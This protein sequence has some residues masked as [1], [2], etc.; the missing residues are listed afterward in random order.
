MAAATEARNTRLRLMA[1][2]SGVLVPLD[3]VPDPVFAQRLVGDGVS[4]DPVSAVLLAPC[5]GRITQLH[6]AAHALTIATAAGVEVMMHIGLDTV[7]LKGRG[8]VAR[9][10]TGDDVRTG[11]TLIEFDADFV[12]TNARSLLTQ[13]IITSAD[14]V[15]GLRAHSGVVQAGRDVI[16]EADVRSAAG[17]AP[18]AASL[19]GGKVESDDIVVSNATGLHARPAAVLAARARAFKSEIRLRRDGQEANAKSVVAIMALEV[20]GGQSVR[21]VAEG[22]DAGEAVA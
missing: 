7:G 12:A 19:G 4:V 3:D 11:D 8:F 15:T 1:P 5:D 20:A 16:L 10:K 9:V 22:P 6:S 17:V 13:V 2:L 14:R 21:F 18:A